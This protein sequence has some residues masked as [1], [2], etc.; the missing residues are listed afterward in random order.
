[1]AKVARK[2][3]EVGKILRMANHYLAAKNTTAD[4]REGVASFIEAVLHESGNYHGFC[5]LPAKDYPDEVVYSGT[6]RFYYPSPKIRDEHDAEL[7][8]I[9]KIR[10]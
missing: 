2:T 7:R 5:Y 10:V 8:D 1:M 6:R 4:E 9:N 3:I